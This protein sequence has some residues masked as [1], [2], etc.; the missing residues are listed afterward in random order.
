MSEVG[1]GYSLISPG[2]YLDKPM[3]GYLGGSIFIVLIGL[4]DDG[5][6]N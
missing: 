2:R 1:F 5:L 3:L 6:I 4:I